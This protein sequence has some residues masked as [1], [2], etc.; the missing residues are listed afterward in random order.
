ML[1][2]V[3]YKVFV[4]MGL[5]FPLLAFPCQS[6]ENEFLK[7]QESMIRGQDF[8]SGKAFAEKLM[9]QE[10]V[11]IPTVV[12]D[13]DPP[14]STCPSSFVGSTI[15]EEKSNLK[16]SDDTELLVFVSFSMPLNTLKSLSEEAGKHGARL[17]LRGLVENSFQKTTEKLMDFDQGLEINPDLFRVY[18][19]KEAPSFVLIEKG[20][21]KGRLVGNVTLS[22]AAQK[23]RGEA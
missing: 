13:Q 19:I 8:E 14:S 17:I 12:K 10:K 15:L 22:Y 6:S 20:K 2:I 16:S 7:N 11:S 21:E 3:E 23:M 5:L 18:D 1:F 4:A 9:S